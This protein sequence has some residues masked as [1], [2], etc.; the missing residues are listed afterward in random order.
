MI[1]GI[2]KSYFA[3]WLNIFNFWGR[4][5]RMDAIV[6]IVGSFVLLIIYALVGFCLYTYFHFNIDNPNAL[7][8]LRL[9]GHSFFKCTAQEFIIFIELLCLLTLGI[10]R[11]HDTGQ[12]GFSLLY[13]LIPVIG[14]LYLFLTIFCAPSNYHSQ[15]RHEDNPYSKVPY[16]TKI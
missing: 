1:Q 15:E 7:I 10:R 9:F 2:I 4:A 14:Q 16:Q 6:F 12:S 13:Y 3:T 8:S 5:T 11:L